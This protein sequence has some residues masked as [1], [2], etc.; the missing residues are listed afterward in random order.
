MNSQ[1]FSRSQ[2]GFQSQTAASIAGSAANLEIPA[3]RKPS[4]QMQS[5]L[6]IFRADPNFLASVA[7]WIDL[8]NET[9]RWDK[10]FRIPFGSGH[11]A[12]VTFAYGLWVDKQ[13]LGKDVFECCLNMDFRLK[14]AAVEALRLRWGLCG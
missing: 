7:P 14:A 8:N 3:N 13:R 12:A 6:L 4:Q 10:I 5:V 1:Q 2:P 9:I 11:Q